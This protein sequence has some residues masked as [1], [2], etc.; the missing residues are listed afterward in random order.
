MIPEV[1]RIRSWIVIGRLTGTV[2]AVGSPLASRAATRMLANF[3]KYLLSG[4][5]IRI[6]PCS[7]SIKAPTAVIGL[8][9]EAMLKMVSVV[10]AT[11]AALPR[12]PLAGEADVFGLGTRQR[13]VG[14]RGG[15]S[16]QAKRGRENFDGSHGRLP[17]GL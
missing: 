17:F 13:I 5:S 6:L 11:P 15:G 16:Q 12:Q 9:I 10:M 14:E 2:S 3:G 7:Y 4:S 1:W 8:V